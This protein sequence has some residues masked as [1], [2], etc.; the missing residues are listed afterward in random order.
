M[1]FNPYVFR[2]YDIRGKVAEDFPREFV[3]DLGRA[4]GTFVKRRGAREIGMS[5]DIR[6]TTPR[7]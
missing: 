1:D 7:L 3:E 5:G 4:F 6:L 2:E